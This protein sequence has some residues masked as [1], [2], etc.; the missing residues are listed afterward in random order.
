MTATGGESNMLQKD[1]TIG[2]HLET[3]ETKDEAIQFSVSEREQSHLRRAVRKVFQYTRRVEE[4]TNPF[5]E[6]SSTAE[7]FQLCASYMYCHT[8]T[9]AISAMPKLLALKT[10]LP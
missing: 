6:I 3:V 1:N 9:G 7:C 10:T 5:S 4:M 2:D 8:W